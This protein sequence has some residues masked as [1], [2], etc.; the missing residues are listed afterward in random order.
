M[1]LR[2]KHSFK[3]EGFKY[4]GTGDRDY[5]QGIIRISEAFIQKT[6]PSIAQWPRHQL[7]FVKN[8]GNN[9]AAVCIFRPL[10][11]SED[12]LICLEYDDRLKL[13]ALE[14]GSIYNLEIKK[15]GWWK[16]LMFYWKH[17]NP[18]IRLDFK[19]AF[20]LT[21]ISIILGTLLSPL[22]DLRFN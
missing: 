14:K 3:I 22:I 2:V 20:Y 12:N 7:V 11:S 15:A 19:L 16:S 9:S 17:P 5:G 10:R 21:I 18:L 13:G 6:Q 8:I 1:E 4:A